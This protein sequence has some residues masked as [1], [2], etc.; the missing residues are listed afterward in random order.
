[1]ALRL[2][3]DGLVEERA[4]VVVAVRCIV[5]MTARARRMNR[6]SEGLFL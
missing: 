2:S 4:V 1:M 5:T 3:A 6:P